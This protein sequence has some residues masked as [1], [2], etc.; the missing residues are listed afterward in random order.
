MHTVAIVFVVEYTLMIVSR[1]QA[2][3]RWSASPAHRSTTGSPSTVTATH[4]PISKPRS[5][6]SVNASA[7][8]S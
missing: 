8:R 4:A 5:K 1:S 6:L 3:P 2:V 7:T